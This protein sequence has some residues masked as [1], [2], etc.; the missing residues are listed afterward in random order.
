MIMI[1]ILNTFNIKIII[2]N[3]LSLQTLTIYQWM[4]YFSIHFLN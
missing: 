2:I 1:C 4:E 3:D